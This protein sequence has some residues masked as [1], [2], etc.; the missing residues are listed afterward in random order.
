M[1][2]FEQE[3]LTETTIKSQLVRLVY[4][5][6]LEPKTFRIYSSYSSSRHIRYC[7]IVLNYAKF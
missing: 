1:K 4:G 2:I 3:V 5:K 7:H 6:R